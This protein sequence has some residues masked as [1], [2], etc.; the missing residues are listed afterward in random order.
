MSEKTVPYRRLDENWNLRATLN[1]K[2]DIVGAETGPIQAATL[3]VI[4]DEL[5]KLNRLLHCQNFVAIP[6]LLKEIKRG[7]CRRRHLK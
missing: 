2:G 5:R 3:L 1:E 4:R 6:R 7:K